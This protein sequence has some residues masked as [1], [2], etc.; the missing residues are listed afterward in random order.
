MPTSNH[1]VVQQSPNGDLIVDDMCKPYMY[2]M[3]KPDQ[4]SIAP[5]SPMP[6]NH[7]QTI[8]AHLITSYHPT[9]QTNKRFT[10]FNTR[11]A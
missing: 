4:A 11:E 7:F 1:A 2:Y 3:T 10:D 6:T 8:F 5:A 9:S